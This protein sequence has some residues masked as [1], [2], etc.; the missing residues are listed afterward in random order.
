MSSYHRYIDPK[1]LKHTLRLKA[2]SR[3]LKSSNSGKPYEVYRDLTPV[4][5]PDYKLLFQDR[6]LSFDYFADTSHAK[7]YYK[8]SNALIS[9]VIELLVY[10]NEFGCDDQF[11]KS[12]DE[13]TTKA[14]RVGKSLV[15]REDSA[16]QKFDMK[17]SAISG[18]LHAKLLSTA[19]R[20][21]LHT[22]GG[23]YLTVAKGYL[24]ALQ[25]TV[26]EEGPFRILQE[27]IV[28]LEEY[29]SAQPTMVL[30]GHLFGLI[31]LAEY[32]A[33][34]NDKEVQQIFED[35]LRS[36]FTYLP[37]FWQGDN[38]LYSMYH[39]DF[40]NVHYLAIVHFQF[41]HLHKLTGIS[42]FQVEAD[43][44]RSECPWPIFDRLMGKPLL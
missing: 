19:L 33:I 27:N 17:S 21:H 29:P 39:W 41:V 20:A 12:V 32:V 40:C 13:V 44:L 15:H 37:H 3:K 5:V 30:N 24:N 34:T 2:Q 11:L 7:L 18:I 31:A 4:S 43:R 16:Y 9:R 1:Y 28:W 8:D 14:E 36:T 6:Y 23:K 10:Y 22:D 26:A 35:C 42:Y 38:L 25:I